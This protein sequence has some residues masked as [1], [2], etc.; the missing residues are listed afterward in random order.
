MN[1]PA[2]RVAAPDA[3]RLGDLTSSL[4]RHGRNL[5]SDYALL[6]VLDA[7]LAAVRFGWLVAAGLV[8]AVLF[9][10]A[11][12]ALVVAAVVALT[13][14][15]TSWVAALGIA[16]AVNVLGGAALALWMRGYMRELPFAATLRQL[17][18]EPARSTE[19]HLDEKS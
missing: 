9:S 14:D 18:G 3:P 17:R 19:V 2:E 1:A 16:G 12:L 11:W 4:L 10:T 8:A 7:R 13:R 6:A 15:G 5:A